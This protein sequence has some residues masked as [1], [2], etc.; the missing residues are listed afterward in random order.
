MP[1][2]VGDMGIDRLEQV[3]AK[4][5]VICL[6]SGEWCTGGGRSDVN[7]VFLGDAG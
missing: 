6:S 3:I 4:E 5:W 7:L 2:L 1:E